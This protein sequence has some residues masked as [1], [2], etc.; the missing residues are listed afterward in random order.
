LIPAGVFLLPALAVEERKPVATLSFIITALVA[1]S[2]VGAY[3]ELFSIHRDAGGGYAYTP[4]LPVFKR[5]VRRRG[6]SRSARRTV[7]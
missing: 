6:L 1:V 2:T 3:I 4:N 7:G 5:S